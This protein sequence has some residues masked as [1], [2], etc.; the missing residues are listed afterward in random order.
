MTKIKEE[1]NKSGVTTDYILVK[2]AR[3]LSEKHT[4]NEN[5]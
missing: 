1:A 5:Y 2:T 4:Q 3:D